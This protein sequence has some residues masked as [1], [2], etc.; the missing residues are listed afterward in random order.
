MPASAFNHLRNH[1][2]RRGQ[3]FSLGAKLRLA[4]SFPDFAWD[5]V[6]AVTRFISEPR[7][8]LPL[9]ELLEVAPR[10][11][12]RS[13]GEDWAVSLWSVSSDGRFRR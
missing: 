4:F 12:R 5:K 6:H 9:A 3:A 7:Y 11:I 8:S 13:G 2:I 1:R 10:H